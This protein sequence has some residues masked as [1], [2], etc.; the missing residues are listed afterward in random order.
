MD[1]RFKLEKYKNP[2][3][4]HTCP[5]C[6]HR[7]CF[8][9]YVDSEN[10]IAFP[11]YVG[12]CDREDKCGYHFTPKMYFAQD[13]SAMP[14]KDSF[15][16]YSL[17][18]T[19][20]QSEAPSYMDCS[21]MEKTLRRYEN[22]NLFLFFSASI[23]RKRTERLFSLY[24]VGT[25]RHWDG[26]TVFWQIDRAG[27]VHAG[28]VMLYDAN[29]GRRVK[30]P[31]N[32]ISWVHS[33][34]KMK[35]F[36]LCQCLFGEHLL[37]TDPQKTVAIVESEKTA[38][39][40]SAYLPQLIWLATG[41]KNT[42]MNEHCLSVLKGRNVILFPDLGAENQWREKMS[43]FTKLGINVMTFEYLKKKASKE[44]REKGYDIGDC[45]ISVPPDK[46]LLECMIAMYPSLGLLVD[47]LDAE[48]CDEEKTDA[49][50][51]SLIRSP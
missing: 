45:L 13:P 28:K 16:T 48:L 19:D 51:T 9:R 18:R 12:R 38:L 17:Q 35:D 2:S 21:L 6:G 46:V 20:V 47:Y 50:E 33:V 49:E 36:N 8:V 4:K 34:L 30:H 31:F 39:I 15:V 27:R 42:C 22:N 40:S 24:R 3:S 1:Y 10:E 43:I 32:H 25:S 14:Q 44:E 7:R 41:G 5:Q 37:N 29:T 26:A 11:E 23:G